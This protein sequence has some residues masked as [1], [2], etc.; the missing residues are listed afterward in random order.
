MLNFLAE[1]DSRD[2]GAAINWAGDLNRHCFFLQTLILD[3]PPWL[4][5]IPPT[6]FSVRLFLPLPPLCPM[7]AA[8]WYPLST[9]RLRVIRRPTAVNPA[10][11]VNR[12]RDSS[13]S[14]ESEEVT[15]E[16]DSGFADDEEASPDT[17][18]QD[19]LDDDDDLD[20]FDDIDEDDFDDNFDD[21]FEEEADD[22]YEIEIDDEISTEFGLGS[23]ANKEPAIEDGLEDFEDFDN[24]D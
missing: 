4:L 24:V 18:F 7:Q 17:G 14:G 12:D 19:D 2:G 8:Q 6:P 23:N 1:F 21:D 16:E 20:E 15:E 13:E 10:T 3:P 11:A 22:D 9:K 5:L